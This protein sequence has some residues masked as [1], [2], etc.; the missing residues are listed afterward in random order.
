MN[1][2]KLLIL[3]MLLKRE[4]YQYS[5]VDLYLSCHSKLYFASNLS[6][7]LCKKNFNHKIVITSETF[8][9]FSKNHYIFQKNVC[10]I[11]GISE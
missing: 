6:Y 5:G 9:K 2:K 7:S 10:N 3:W 1:E 11:T 4:K 8:V